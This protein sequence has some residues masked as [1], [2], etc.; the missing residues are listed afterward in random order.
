MEAN[1]SGENAAYCRIFAVQGRR[2][3]LAS[4]NHDPEFQNAPLCT[5]KGHAACDITRILKERIRFVKRREPLVAPKSLQSFH[6]L[7]HR[8]G[9]RYRHL[10]ER[11]RISRKANLLV[12]DHVMDVDRPRQLW[13]RRCQRFTSPRVPL[14]RAPSV[15]A[16]RARADRE[17]RRG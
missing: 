3:V 1:S 16:H 12:S 7:Q 15:S 6:R 10:V 9:V 14:W 2:R 5:V 11:P 4:L 17:S 13:V 8:K